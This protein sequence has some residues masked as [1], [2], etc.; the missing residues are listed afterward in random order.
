MY[1]LFLNWAGCYA[2]RAGH[3]GVR[4]GCK[5]VR[6]GRS[7]LRNMPSWYSIYLGFFR[8][9]PSG[10]LILLL[11]KIC[12]VICRWDFNSDDCHCTQLQHLARDCTRLV[13]WGFHSV[14]TKRE[15]LCLVLCVL[16]SGAVEWYA[17]AGGRLRTVERGERQ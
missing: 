8:R 10:V 5:I 11:K 2:N 15:S 1:I 14:E 6:A 17:G 4:A 7:T 12:G 3:K 13:C 16:L 9:L